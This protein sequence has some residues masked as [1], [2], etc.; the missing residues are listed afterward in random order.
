MKKVFCIK[1]YLFLL[2]IVSL[3]LIMPS[4]AAAEIGR[5]NVK[6]KL[7]VR[8][9]PTTK[10]PVIYQLTNGEEVELVDTVGDWVKISVWN[11]YG[12]VKS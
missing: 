10:S 2:I 8:Q 4:N 5:I 6:G 9:E 11:D 3:A 7:N 1:Q 12:Y